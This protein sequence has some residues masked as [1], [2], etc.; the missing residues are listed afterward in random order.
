MSS[1][2]LLLGLAVI[3]LIGVA[4]F[5]L[6]SVAK[7]RVVRL[8]KE[9]YQAAWLGIENSL[10]RLDGKT[11]RL[12]VVEADKLLDEALREMYIKGN[13]LGERL[14]AGRNKFSN[15]NA[16]WAS[17][18]LRNQI[19]HERNVKVSY[20]QAERALTAYRKALQDLGAI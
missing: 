18:R 7:F 8:E 14:K 13:N 6:V 1:A 16:V 11:Y 12:S 2:Y 20:E 10:E 17:H 5:G 9:K 4:I 15:I 19:V 3:L